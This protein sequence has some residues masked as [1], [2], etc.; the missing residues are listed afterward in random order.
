MRVEIIPKLLNADTVAKTKQ[1]PQSFIDILP[2]Y[3][4]TSEYIFLNLDIFR[5]FHQI[6]LKSLGAMFRNTIFLPNDSRYYVHTKY[7]PQII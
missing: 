6:H 1:I 7:V 4:E 2:F 3:M 5:I